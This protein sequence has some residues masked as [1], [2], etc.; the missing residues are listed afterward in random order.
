MVSAAESSR[1]ETTRRLC[2]CLLVVMDLRGPLPGGGSGVWGVRM[3]C[4]ERSSGCMG[5]R[6]EWSP[7]FR[8]P[9]APEALC[10]ARALLLCP[11]YDGCGGTREEA[12]SGG[13]ARC[14]FPCPLPGCSSGPQPQVRSH[15][16]EGV[17]PAFTCG[18]MW[19]V[20]R[21]HPDFPAVTTVRVCSGAACLAPSSAVPSSFS[22]SHVV[23]VFPSFRHLSVTES[24]VFSG[25][26]C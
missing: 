22:F 18:T 13:C 19:R 2:S 1:G 16:S 21:G 12:S 5:A 7:P 4:T 8:R 25:F 9:P 15:P 17:V 11:G 6:G 3:K 14:L 10:G 23:V 20:S 26:N 24:L